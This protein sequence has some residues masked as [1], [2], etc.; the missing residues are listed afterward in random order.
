MDDEPTVVLVVPIA[1]APT[2]NGLAMRAGMLLDALAPAAAVHVVI[3]PVAGSADDLAWASERA[4][5]VTVVHPIRTGTARDHTTRQLADAEL[6]ERLER[7]APL[8]TRAA[9]A[10][11]T[12]V[13]EIEAALSVDAQ[14]PASVLTM[15]LYLAPLGIRLARRLGAQRT[16]VDIDD[17]D[18]AL[19]RAM[20]EDIEADAFDRLAGCWLPDAD[21]VFA[22]SNESADGLAVRTGLEPIGVVPNA[23]AIPRTRSAPPGEDRLLFVG[24]LTYP[25]N[26]EAARLVARELLPRVREQ[27]PEASLELVGAHHG[28]LDDLAGLAGVRLTGFVPDLAPHYDRADVVVVPLR[29]GSGT[30]IKVIEAFAHRRPVVATTVAV[31][32]LDVDAGQDVVVADSL[33]ELARGILDV[34]DD[35]A[36]AA[37]MVEHAASLVEAT[38]TPA[39]VG[40]LVRS[41][42]LVGSG[43]G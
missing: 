21:V 33:E 34:L 17:D 8:P 4:R 36:R 18:G 43:A 29:H 6:R 23:I 25:P 42:V 2:G 28:A 39:V 37:R 38:Y 32:G 5:S 11:P 3:V 1:P 41:A 27:R 40:E 24:N 22:A 7:T 13:D 15:R 16:A 35:P 26:Q 9:L 10:P 30:R 20:G 19:L 12:L 31:S 14:T